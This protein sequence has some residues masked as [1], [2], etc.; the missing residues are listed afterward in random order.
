MR[1]S[2]VIFY[3]QLLI[4]RAVCLHGR[5]GY[6]KWVNI[7]CTEKRVKVY[8]IMALLF[9]GRCHFPFDRV[10]RSDAPNVK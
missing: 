5:K 2:K 7:K 10:I 6:I 4:A 8:I 9:N 3:A 1:L